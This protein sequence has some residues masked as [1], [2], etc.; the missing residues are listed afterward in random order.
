M[1]EGGQP[2]TYTLVLD[3]RPTDTVT[4][5]LSS[6]GDGLLRI[7]PDTLTFTT[8]DWNTPQTISVSAPD[9]G[10]VSTDRYASIIHAVSG[11][12]YGSVSV[13]DIRVLI[14]NTTQAYI[15]LD[16]AQASE[17]DGYVEFT[18]SVRPILRTVPVVVRY[19][20]VD[21]TAAAGT[22]YTRQVNTGQTY[23]IF[24]IPANG[25]AATIRIP[26]TDNEVYGPAK[27]TF[28][29]QLTNQ[30]NKALLDG[31][32]T[33]LT[34][35][36]SIIDDDPKPVASVAGP[37]G[38]LS[39]VSEDKKGP[40][41]FT[42]TLTGR[43][44]ADVTVDYS[45]GQAQVLSRLTARQGITPATAGEDY[46]AAT[47][48]VTFSP[49][50]ATKQVTVQVTDDDV[51][52]DTEFFGFKI[53]NAQNAQLRNDAT[54]E[55]ADVGLLDDD[56]RGVVINPT[57]I[58][59]EEPAPGEAAVASSYTVKLNSKPTDTVTVTVTVGSANPAVAL[60]GATL[61]NTNTLTFTT[62][63]WDTA[64]TVTVTPVED[65]NG[66]AETITLTH[67]QSGGDYTGIAADSVTVNV[68]DNDTRNVVLSPTSL[69]VTE[70]DNTGVGYTVK[71]STQPSDTVTVTI[72]GHSRTDLSISGSTLNSNRLTFSTSNWDTAQTVTVKAGDDGN[73]DD[74]SETLTHTA[75]GGDYAN[76]SKNL[77]VT[78]S[79][80]APATVTVSFGS[81]A[82]TVAESSTVTVTVTLDADPERTVVIP[83]EAANQGGASDSDYSGVP[84]NV[85][86]N[87]GDTSRSFT[88]TAAHDTDDDDGESVK[89]SFGAT[90][91]TVVTAGTPATS[92]VTITDDD[93]PQVT[94]AFGQSTYSAAEGSTVT[95]EVTLSADPERN[96]S[97]PIEKTN[98]GGATTADYSGVPQNVT[99]D[100]GDTEKT[101]VF[102]AAHDTVDDDDESVNLSFGATLPTGVTAGTPATSTIT[103]TDDDVPSVTVSFGSAAYTVAESDDPGSTGVTENT[104]EVTVE[105]SADPERTVVIPIEKSIQDGAST[106]DYFGVPESVTFDS[107][108]T[109]KSFTFTAAHD[110]VDDDGER[111][112]LSFGATLPTR[113]TAGTP[114]TSTITIT[115]DDVPSVVLSPTSLT[116]T[117]GDTTGASYT[118][119]LSLQPSD[120]V[121]VTITGHDGTDLNIS[122]TTLNAS[123]QLT[124]TTAIWDTAQ[125]VTVKADHDENAVSESLK[126]IHTPSGGVSAA[127][128]TVTVTDD[129]SAA[130]VLSPTSLTVTEGDETGDSYTVKLS[131]QPSD[132]V[133]V[134]IGG[135]SGTDLSISGSTLNSNR[136]TFSTSNWDTAQTVTVKAGHDGKRG[137]RV[138]NPDAHGGG[139][140]LCER[141]QEPPRLRLRRRP[142]H[143]DRELRQRHLHG[144]GGLLTD[145]HRQPGRRPRAH[146]HHPHRGR[147]RGRRIRLRLHRRA[148]ERD[149][150]GRRHLTDLRH[151][152]RGGQPCGVGGEGQALLRHPPN[153][154]DG[155]HSRRDHRLH[156]R[157]DP[158][159]GPAD[160]AHCPLRDRRLLGGRRGN[161]GREGEAEQGAG[162]RGRHTHLQGQPCRGLRQ[163]LHRG[164]RLP[165]LRSGGHRENH[166]I[167]GHR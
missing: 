161:R 65:T 32:A 149:L 5:N 104:V 142:G 33:S 36:G 88:F 42:L 167:C 15:Y 52:E 19:T 69:T 66:T 37:A 150:R 41:T 91:P 84:Q 98:E 10:E 147:Q 125:T 1:E 103:I 113:V 49:G 28:T 138:G 74:E 47:G 12:D 127:D 34:A 50:D 110:T 159:P 106:A 154:R 153:R 141:L 151:L 77:P 135:H 18:V 146:S 165:H 96:V 166:H 78:V 148:R 75:A 124:F 133:T 162:Q 54:E 9:D 139:R 16:D 130:I 105:L 116:V 82:Y 164:S 68:T 107:G 89:L 93:D 48:T 38:D 4:I 129:D 108:K 70:G 29:L 30:N 21:G 95:V 6:S 156:L 118:V 152:R 20:T 83:I 11:G 143:R 90:L 57:S 100:S 87:A 102:T 155:G 111:V 126:L 79:D 45:T 39:Y 145:R 101:F 8:S 14:E 115:D 25:G 24:N 120:A 31:D 17:S 55:V 99:F 158:G 35:T 80:D 123:N 67:I 59:L 131:T 114:A 73:A 60:S 43:S 121:T 140:R 64:Q 71:L 44:A 136:L 86:F 23:K 132:T 51:S 46:T 157:Q 92:T 122:G 81:A 144:R 63:N 53:S 128:L 163:R 62:S 26:I 160:S 72:G 112:Q 22:D 117:E 58:S 119:K 56:P 94:V 97:I 2:L 76:V 85:T 137:R 3:S 40:V 13:G 134:T 27:K 61:S 109:S 7:V